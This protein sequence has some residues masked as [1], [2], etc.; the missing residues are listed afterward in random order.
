M[1]RAQA[2]P[3]LRPAAGAAASPGLELRDLRC[4]VAVADAGSFARATERTS[5]AQPA[6]SQ[7][8]RRLEEIVGT[9]L[10]QRRREGLQFTAAGSVVLVAAR[11]VLSRRSR[12][13]PHAAGRRR[14]RTAATADGRLAGPGRGPAGKDGRHAA[15]AAV[16]VDVTWLENA[17]DAEFSLIRTCR[18][19]A[20]SLCPD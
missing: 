6:L 4:F 10:L 20:A 14:H 18:R 15:G 7:R 2:Q 8:I 17:L 3:L 19:Q 13:E 1:N 11:N 5:I 12:G 9:P 16:D